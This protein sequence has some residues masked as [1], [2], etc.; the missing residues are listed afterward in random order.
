MA[1]RSAEVQRVLLAVDGRNKGCT[2]AAPGLRARLEEGGFRPVEVREAG[3]ITFSDVLVVLGGD[4]F[5][6]H[7]LADLGYPSVAVLGLNFGQ[8]GFLMNHPEHVRDLAEILRKRQYHVSELP[9]VAARVEDDE[10]RRDVFAINDFVL[11]RVAGQTVRL[12]LYIEGVL[13]NRYS[14]DGLIVAT[15]TGSTAYTLAAGGPVVHPGV[16]ALVVTPVNAH[17]PIQFHSLQFPLVLP[18]DAHVEIKVVDRGARPTRLV[19]DGSLVGTPHSI[20][21]HW[22]RRSIHLIRTAEFNYVRALVQKV[23]GTNGG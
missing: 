13:L 16:H 17:R 9:I 23:I 19:A 18:L 21:I 1:E 2:Q 12:D 7:T 5:L 10:G 15:G 22:S 3:E 8:V 20:A 4:G 11:E 14:G 6:M